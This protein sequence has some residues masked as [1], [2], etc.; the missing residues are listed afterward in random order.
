MSTQPQ[1]KIDLAAYRNDDYAPGKS[2]LVR[3]IWF[4]TN[5]LFFINPAFPFRGFKV[6][7]LRLF[8]AKIGTGVVIKP[9]VN[10]K[11]P[12]Y[13]RVGDHCWIG[14]NVWIDNLTFVTLGDHV[15]LSQGAMLLT[16]N[17]D[18]T[19]RSF[20]LIVGEIRLEDGCW[21]GAHATVCPGVTCSSHAI[22][23]VKSVATHDLE[24]Y[25]V[26]Q[27]NPAKRIRDRVIQ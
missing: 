2:V 13:L 14:E 4:V 9:N 18:Y 3:L 1:P 22:L 23:T 25:S 24:P 27:G 15:C 20:N 10:I 21:I 7:L 12:W 5:V 26:Y 6:F 17:H 19:Q 11:Y 16:G 8:G